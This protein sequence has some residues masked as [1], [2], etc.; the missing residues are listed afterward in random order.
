[1]TEE[2][3]KTGN[4]SPETE[5][6]RPD[7]TLVGIDPAAPGGDQTVPHIANPEALGDVQIQPGAAEYVPAPQNTEAAELSTEEVANLKPEEI[8]YIQADGSVQDHQGETIINTEGDSVEPNANAIPHSYIPQVHDLRDA[9]GGLIEKIKA[10]R[11]E[12]FGNEDEACGTNDEAE[13]LKTAFDQATTTVQVAVQQI[14]DR[15]A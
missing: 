1:M 8:G 6:T 11:T 9:E 4:F 13:A 14:I 7:A 2:E 12:I 15:T 3:F 5:A 10:L